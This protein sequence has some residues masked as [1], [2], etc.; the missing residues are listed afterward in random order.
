MPTRTERTRRT[1]RAG[2]TLVE[3][4]IAGSIFAL[5][6]LGAYA[7][8]SRDATLSR[9]SLGISVAEMRAQQMLFAIEREVAGARGASPRTTATVALA[10]GATA[11]LRVA[12]T[13]GFPDRGLL[14]V[15]RGTAGLERIAYDSL[16]PGAASFLALTRGEQ[17]TN[18]S[19]HAA[20]AEVL[21]AALA[22]TL[23][24]P[25]NPPA[26]LF[27]GRALEAGGPVWF[28]G[29]GTGFS[30]RVPTDP[31]GG[32]AVLTDGEITWGATVGGAPT[33]EGWASLAFDPSGEVREDATGDDLNGDGDVADV[34]DVGR[35]R[36]RTWDT[37][38]P[39]APASDL[40]L[41][42]S[43]VLQERC[44]WGGDLD[45]DGFDDPIFLWDGATRRLHVR[46]FVLGRSVA[47][48]PIVRRV[49]SVIFLRNDPQG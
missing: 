33:L 25:A 29:D 19:S 4:L 16:G 9:S 40:G 17:C 39:A 11:E 45:A 48:L 12:S 3:S 24:L 37:S 21:W 31:A 38:D 42:P 6:I 44:G 23:V 10:A 8:L 7:A 41:G 1:R 27:D 15:D 2:F 30:Y 13:L 36:R 35:I 22:E 34:F 18:P 46:L 26:N 32:A 14:L 5:V 20:G 49:E 47:D 43:V 28:R